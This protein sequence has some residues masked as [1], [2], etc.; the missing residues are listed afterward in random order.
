MWTYR[1]DGLLSKGHRIFYCAMA[2]KLA[3]IRGRNVA[4]SRD[5]E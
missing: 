3:H 5:D 4:M 1:E 2:G